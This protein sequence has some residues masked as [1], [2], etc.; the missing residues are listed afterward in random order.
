MKLGLLGARHGLDG[1]GLDYESDS[2]CDGFV[3]PDDDYDTTAVDVKMTRQVSD[4]DLHHG[5]KSSGL[6]KVSKGWER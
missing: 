4:T 5:K 2:S 3:V 6:K 1:R